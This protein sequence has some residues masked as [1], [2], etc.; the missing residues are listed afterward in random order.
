MLSQKS[1]TALQVQSSN[2]RVVYLDLVRTVC[3]LVI[4]GVWHGLDYIN[5]AVEHTALDTLVSQI[6]LT[7]F[8]FLSG[9]LLSKYSVANIN[10]ILHF[11]KKRLSR[12]FL[13]FIL[14]AGS[15]YLGG[16]NF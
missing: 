1:K 5:P 11:Y 10:D 4:V 9:Y 13:M 8:M 6:C 12:F 14:S 3:T 7:C 16:G 2:K 15:L